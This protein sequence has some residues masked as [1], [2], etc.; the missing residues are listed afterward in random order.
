MSP[1]YYNLLRELDL[2]AWISL[3]FS[4]EPCG[5]WRPCCQLCPPQ[6]DRSGGF[7]ICWPQVCI[8]DDCHAG[9]VNYGFPPWY[10]PLF[11]CTSDGQC[12]S[13]LKIT[14][15]INKNNIKFFFSWTAWS[16]HIE[17]FPL[18]RY[19]T[20]HLR[21]E[22]DEVLRKSLTVNKMQ[23]KRVD[24]ACSFPSRVASKCKGITF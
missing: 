14:V 15:L 9:T 17:C 24:I 1:C 2:S 22:W 3:Q 10:P 18:S 16:L 4:V 5:A 8:I 19:F 7:L 23:P 21:D 12:N 20:S 13:C 6:S 11:T